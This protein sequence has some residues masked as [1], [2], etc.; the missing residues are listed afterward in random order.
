MDH[1]VVHA[2]IVREA[3]LGNEQR[4]S[5]RL[6][7]LGKGENCDCEITKLPFSLA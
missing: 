6:D 5:A 7:L 3:T 1:P 4:I 2:V